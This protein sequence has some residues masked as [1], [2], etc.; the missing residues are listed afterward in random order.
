MSRIIFKYP[1]QCFVVAATI[2]LVTIFT[3]LDIY[4]TH[5]PLTLVT[6]DASFEVDT[7]KYVNG[8]LFYRIDNTDYI[9]RDV[10]LLDVEL[11]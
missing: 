6:S 11:N 10:K 8:V 3:F 2:I 7:Y 4:N 9:E 1:Y 5:R